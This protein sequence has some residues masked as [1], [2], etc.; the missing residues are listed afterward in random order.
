MQVQEGGV[1]PTARP[2]PSTLGSAGKKQEAFDYARLGTNGGGKAKSQSNALGGVVRSPGMAPAHAAKLLSAVSPG[3]LDGVYEAQ[4]GSPTSML[5][6]HLPED[7]QLSCLPA[8]PEN[9]AEH[10]DEEGSAVGSW[11]DVLPVY[12]QQACCPCS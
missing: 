8:N 4:I 2:H 12:G 7:S 1:R 6:Q 3:L 10:G 11:A 5:L 9:A